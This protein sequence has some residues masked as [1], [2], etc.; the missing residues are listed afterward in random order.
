MYLDVISRLT[1]CEG[2]TDLPITQIVSTVNRPDG[3]L[4]EVD[5]LLGCAVSLFPLLDQ[6]VNLIQKVRMLQ[7]NTLRIVTNASEL[8][9][10]LQQWRAPNAAMFKRCEDPHSDVQH[11][12]Q[13]AEALRYAAILYIHQAVP[14]LAYVPCNTIA[15]KILFKLASVPS[16]SLAT[17][18]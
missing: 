13:T 15:K 3:P 16:Q 12:I 11:N 10:Q 6:M 9:R 4:L 2:V 5:P 1:T 18:L 14:E 17:N 7:N 8:V